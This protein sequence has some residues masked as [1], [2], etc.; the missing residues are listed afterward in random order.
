MPRPSGF[1]TARHSLHPVGRVRGPLRWVG[2]DATADGRTVRLWSSLLEPI[3]TLD[4]LLPV[5]HARRPEYLITRLPL[6]CSG[7]GTCVFALR[8]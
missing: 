1:A 8:W 4:V 2:V 3:A 6:P 5:T 7:C